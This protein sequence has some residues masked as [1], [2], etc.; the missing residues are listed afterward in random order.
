MSESYYIVVN[1][2]LLIQWWL[3]CSGT[4][5][6]SGL[7]KSSKYGLKIEKKKVKQ[8]CMYDCHQGKKW[9]FNCSLSANI[10]PSSLHPYTPPSCFYISWRKNCAFLS[11]L[12]RNVEW[13]LRIYI[14]SSVWLSLEVWEEDYFMFLTTQ[15]TPDF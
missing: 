15:R 11:G 10:T 3:M 14:C 6:L 8:M 13:N 9:C 2:T 12:E 1:K 5:K 4:S 7:V